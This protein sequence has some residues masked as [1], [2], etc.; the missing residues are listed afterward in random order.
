M[1]SFHSIHPQ[2]EPPVVSGRQKKSALSPPTPTDI[3]TYTYT[4]RTNA[5][6]MHS[7]TGGGGVKRIGIFLTAA[8][9][10]GGSL[11]GWMLWKFLSFICV[12]A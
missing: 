3:C 4:Y 1:K 9:A 10:T 7:H 2:R 12:P 6:I 8:L 5:E 11:C